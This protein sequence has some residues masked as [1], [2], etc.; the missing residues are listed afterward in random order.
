MSTGNV[1]TPIEIYTDGSCLG[2][3]GVG[4]YGFIIIYS[5]KNNGNNKQKKLIGHGGRADTTNNKM[6]LLAVI[7][8]LRTIQ[9]KG[10]SGNPITLYSDSQY[11]IKGITEWIK[12]WKT[13]NFKDVK[14]TELWKELDSLTINKKIEW[15]WVK[16]HNGNLYNE[17]VDKLAR[18]E[19]EKLKSQK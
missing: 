15:K 17:R 1:E 19:A 13:R 10:F 3:P 6:E 8:A 14:N 5:I 16:A 12:G 7:K 18:S 4:G 9:K 2:N 11:V